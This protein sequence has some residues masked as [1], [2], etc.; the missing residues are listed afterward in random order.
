MNR[1]LILLLLFSTSGCT[2]AI[3]QQGREG[4]NHDL[5]YAEI[6]ADP[7]AYAGQKTLIGGVI[8]GLEVEQKGSTLEVYRWELDRWGEPYA[9]NE[10]SGR[11]LAETDRLLDPAVYTPGRLVAMA[12]TV[13]GELTRPLG[14]IDYHYPVFRI[15]ESYVWQTPYRYMIY[16]GGNIYAPT[17]IA[18]DD[19]TRDNP[20]NPGYN[21]YPYSPYYL[22]FPAN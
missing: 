10:D 18:P 13:S 9:V 14:Q 15:N 4:V 12:A 21:P 16:P 7:T 11:F 1:F 20:Y 5:D 2:H 8:V 19:P 6:K 17:Y 22:R 3:S